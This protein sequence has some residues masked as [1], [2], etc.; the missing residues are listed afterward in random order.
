MLINEAV[1]FLDKSIPDKTVGLPDEI[2]YFI[3]RVTPL[4]NVDL[5]VKDK[6]GRT[7]LAWRN[8]EQYGNAWHIPGGIIRF[9]ETVSQRIH[10]TGIKEL[11]TEVSFLPEPIGIRQGFALNMDNR[12]HFI[13]FLYRCFVPVDYVPNNAGKDRYDTGY[14]EWHEC[15]PKNLQI[16]QND[17]RQFINDNMDQK[18]YPCIKGK[19]ITFIDFDNKYRGEIIE[20]AN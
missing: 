14:L 19:K 5:L 10:K 11:G 18:E 13:S 8:D 1:A 4:V 12:A 7:L 16:L 15:A 20:S 2:F 9:K 17:Y 3:S 6:Q